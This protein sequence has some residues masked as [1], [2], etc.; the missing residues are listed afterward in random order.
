MNVNQWKDK[1]RTLQFNEDIYDAVLALVQTKSQDPTK[2]TNQMDIQRHLLIPKTDSVLPNL[3]VNVQPSNYTQNNEDKPVITDKNGKVLSNSKRATQ[4][5][6]AQKLFRL[7]R[8]LY[9]KDLETEV[10]EIPN[11]KETIRTLSEENQKLRDYIVSLQD[12]LITEKPE[13]VLNS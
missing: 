5:R 4:N 13:P 9:V 1:D 10:R 7:R 6:I 11:L 2:L 3:P 8:E 12:K